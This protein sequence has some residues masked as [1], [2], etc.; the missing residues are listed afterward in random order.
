MVSAPPTLRNGCFSGRRCGHT[1]RTAPPRRTAAPGHG[2][3][4]LAYCAGEPEKLAQQQLF[5]PF[6][7]RRAGYLLQ[8]ANGYGAPFVRQRARRS[9]A[10]DRSRVFVSRLPHA[11]PSHRGGGKRPPT[12]RSAAQATRFLLCPRGTQGVA[13]RLK[14]RSVL[15]ANAVLSP[16]GATSTLSP[17]VAGQVGHRNVPCWLYVASSG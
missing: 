13:Y 10:P 8:A 16:G 11:S 6:R 2:R 5:C 9:G 17:F 1:A 7:A 12:P 14:R 15:N 4:C 3:V